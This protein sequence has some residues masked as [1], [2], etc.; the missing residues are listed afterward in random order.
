MM[1]QS[2]IDT[3]SGGA[4]MDKMPIVIRHLI[5]NMTS[6]TQQFGI[7]GVGQPR[8]VNEISAV[9]TLRHENQLT[10]LTS[11]V[12]QLVVG[13]HQ[14]SIAARVCGIYTFVGY[15][16]NVC[17]TLQEIESDHLESVGA[18]SGYQYGKQLYQTTI[19]ARAESMALCSSAI[20]ICP[21]CTSN[22]KWLSPAKSTIP[23]TTVPKA[24]TI[25]NATF[26]QLT[27]SRRL[28]EIVSNKQSGVP[29]KHELQ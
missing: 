27:I 10:E 13:Q 22:S 4:L 20:W 6:N 28:D 16:T 24:T 23:S 17:P 9:E 18:I 26:R 3:A 12:R 14:P 8:M 2:M 19:S 15:P 25:E 29:T 21:E 1:D 11:L 5:S 7:K